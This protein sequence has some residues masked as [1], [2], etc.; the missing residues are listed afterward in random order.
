MIDVSFI[1][2]SLVL[3]AVLPRVDRGGWAICLFK[4]QFEVGRSAIGKGGLVQDENAISQAMDGLASQI[5]SLGW[6]IAATI[7][8]PLP[9][10]DDNVERLLH[11]VRTA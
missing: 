6:T 11:L 8:S 7:R 5:P 10:G 4:P 9:G 3:P 1:S 2:L